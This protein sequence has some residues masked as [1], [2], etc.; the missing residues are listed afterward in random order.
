MKNRLHRIEPDTVS[1][2]LLQYF[3]K[4]NVSFWEE[5]ALLSG[6]NLLSLQSDSPYLYDELKNGLHKLRFDLRNICLLCQ[7]PNPSNERFCE[8][9][10]TNMTLREKQVLRIRF[11]I[12][13]PKSD[14]KQLE[15]LKQEQKRMGE[16]IR[17]IEQKSLQKLRH[18]GRDKRRKTFMET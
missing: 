8:R 11:G 6:D 17:E 9:C 13:L 1:I 14:R 2:E 16:R 18:P 7:K 3:A 12:G 5:V 15:A 4:L 10:F